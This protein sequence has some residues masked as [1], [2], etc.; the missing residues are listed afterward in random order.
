[1]RLFRLYRNSKLSV[2]MAHLGT[3]SKKGNGTGIAVQTVLI[4]AIVSDKQKCC[5]GGGEYGN[6]R[7]VAGGGELGTYSTDGDKTCVCVIS[8]IR[9]GSVA[10]AGVRK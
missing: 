10:I 6:G 1:M 3:R 8:R 4:T 2:L 7:R 9:C 5:L